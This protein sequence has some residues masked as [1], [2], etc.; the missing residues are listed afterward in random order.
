MKLTVMKNFLNLKPIKKNFSILK[1]FVYQVL[2]VLFFIGSVSWVFYMLPKNAAE[3]L[4]ESH[5]SIVL[6]ALWFVV[7]IPVVIAFAWLITS[8]KAIKANW[9][10]TNIF[11]LVIVGFIFFAI[12]GI[13]F[14]TLVYLLAKNGLVTIVSIDGRHTIT[15]ASLIDLFMWHSLEAIP[16]LHINDLLKFKEPYDF[17]GKVGALVL[18]FQLSVIFPIIR[19]QKRVSE[20]KKKLKSIGEKYAEAWSSNNPAN[21]AS[22][23]SYRGALIVNDDI[24][25]AGRNNIAKVAERFMS[26]HPDMI[27]TM[28]SMTT[29]LK[30]MEFHWT[31]TRTNSGPTG[32]GEKVR[33]SG[34]ELWQ[35][36]NDGLIS[37]SKDNF[38]AEEHKIGNAN[39]V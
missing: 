32:T 15:I 21:V 2:H 38:A 30:G 7:V 33:I 23:F 34:I 18:L 5:S 17:D 16:S 9:I 39:K 36:D 14:S 20:F 25:T 26:A 12:S 6:R 27:V 29:K 28:E 13:L 8:E 24:L 31:L 11:S 22:F 3:Y 10:K 4:F 35:I 37:I 1:E 19:F